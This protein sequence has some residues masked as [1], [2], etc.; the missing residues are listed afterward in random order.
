MSRLLWSLS[1]RRIAVAGLLI[2]AAAG[3]ALA[4]ASAS[5]AAPSPLA[6]LRAA[7]AR[8]HSVNHARTD[9]FVPTGDCAELPGA[10]A[11]GY[12]FVN[13]E[14]LTDGVVDGNEPEIL[15]YAKDQGG[16]LRL[17]GVEWFAVGGKT[18][19]PRAKRTLAS[20]AAPAPVSRW[21]T[22]D[23]TEPITARDVPPARP[24]QAVPKR[25][26]STL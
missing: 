24:S 16:K 3:A 13:P 7:T 5:E 23:L 14:R 2:V 6:S 22:L 10:G 8:Y 26:T 15:L 19:S 12:H 20:A 25:S 18:P 1:A 17:A 21:P 4:Q 9:G 11:M